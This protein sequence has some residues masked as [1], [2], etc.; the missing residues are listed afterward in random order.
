MADWFPS[1]D[2]NDVF[3]SLRNANFDQAKRSTD[4][5]VEHLFD[6]TR[7]MLTHPKRLPP[8]IDWVN[9]WTQENQENRW[10]AF[11]V[12]AVLTRITTYLGT[13]QEPELFAPDLYDI[14]AGTLP[15]KSSED[16]QLYWDVVAIACPQTNPFTNPV[17]GKWLWYAS[18][19]C[20][21]DTFMTAMKGLVICTL[22]MFRTFAEYKDVPPEQ[23][24][25][26]TFG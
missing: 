10:A 13:G 3:R 16:E 11:E 5:F 6:E 24:W 15:C 21:Q 4:F 12:T 20:P 25:D 18:P 9:N 22:A 8:F 19:T 14:I 26:E 2:P 1:D 7:Q 17:D 23:L